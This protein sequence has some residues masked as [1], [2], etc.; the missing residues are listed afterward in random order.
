VSLDAH[1]PE[2]GAPAYPQFLAIP[3]AALERWDAERHLPAVS[4]VAAEPDAARFLATPQDAA[5][6]AATAARYAA[7]WDSYGFG[8]WAVVPGDG[9]P[10]GWVGAFHPLWH[11]AF[12]DRVE[13][14]WGLAAAAR[15]RGLA[16]AGARAAIDACFS[17][18]GIDEILAF[19]HPPNAASRAVAERV[20]MRPVGTTSEPGRGTLLD[21][22]ALRRDQ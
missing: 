2:A 4:A 20:G 18:L 5:G 6:Q 10:S 22:F 9:E 17:I 11:P 8:R 16:T 7:H 19:I 3:G 13:V 21:V 15:G 12:Q 1:G 14:G